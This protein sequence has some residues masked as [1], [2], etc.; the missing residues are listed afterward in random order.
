MA[1]GF[2]EK[3]SGEDITKVKITQKVKRERMEKITKYPSFSCRKEDRK[4]FLLIKRLK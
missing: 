1:Q 3:Q 4:Y 2:E